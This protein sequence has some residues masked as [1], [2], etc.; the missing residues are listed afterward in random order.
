MSVKSTVPST[1]NST[2]SGLASNPEPAARAA[3][4]LL[5]PRHHHRAVRPRGHRQ[6]VPAADPHPR[7]RDR[8]PAALGPLG[9]V[10]GSS[11]AASASEP[12][13]CRRRRC[14]CRSAPRSR[15]P[16]RLRRARPPRPSRGVPRRPA[17][18]APT[19]SV[20][21]WPVVRARTAVIGGARGDSPPGL[22]LRLVGRWGRGR[23][24]VL[25]HGV[26]CN[27]RQ[28]SA[29]VVHR[30]PTPQ[31]RSWRSRELDQRGQR[32]A[33]VTGDVEQ[34]IGIDAEDDR[35]DRAHDRDEQRPRAAIRA[36]RP[37]S[38]GLGRPA[39]DRRPPAGVS[40]G[41]AGAS[42]GERIQTAAITRR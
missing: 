5:R 11:P 4:P 32:R 7:D 40:G 33:G 18:A 21:A 34:R 19:Y 42:D 8:R 30:R 17:R 13:R 24:A 29:R 3:V 25:L 26:W 2:P 39:G 31:C 28:M 27:R 22:R 16:C 12:G 35:G 37:A 15:P 1:P 6:A 38:V 20:V 36:A 14:R 41:R 10:H 9:D 23:A